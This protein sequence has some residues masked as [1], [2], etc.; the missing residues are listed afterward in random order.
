M[1]TSDITGYWC[2]WHP[3]PQ[4]TTTT[5]TPNHTPQ[6]PRA[7]LAWG[8]ERERLN[9]WMTFLDEDES[10]EDDDCEEY[11]DGEAMVCRH[12]ALLFA[13]HALKNTE[14]LPNK[15]DI[16]ALRR[17]APQELEKRLAH[18]QDSAAALHL[19]C[20]DD[21]GQFLDQ[22]FDA[23]KQ[24]KEPT[25]A[26]D[27]DPSRRLVYLIYTG[28]HLMAMQ[29]RLTATTGDLVEVVTVYDP[30]A[31]NQVVIDERPAPGRRAV[32]PMA[33]DLRQFIFGRDEEPTYWAKMLHEY[34][35]STQI[36]RLQML[37]YELS[38]EPAMACAD[39][40]KTA[41]VRS[42]RA[43][44]S[45]LSS[46]AARADHGRLLDE[47][48]AQAEQG[49]DLEL[50]RHQP[51]HLSA[52]L[53]DVFNCCSQERLTRWQRL[54]EKADEKRQVELL[55]AYSH[56]GSPLGAFGDWV[57]PEA[58]QWWTQR[59]LALAPRQ[60]L[61]VL[62]STSLGG[63]NLLGIGLANSA[64]AGLN[65]L[66]DAI[67]QL[68]KTHADEVRSLFNQR[69]DQN[70]TALSRATSDD[71]AEALAIWL[72]WL[73][74][75]VPLADHRALLEAKD[76][77]GDPALLNAMRNG[78]K[79]W[80]DTWAQG[81][82]KLP[83][84]EVRQLLRAEAGDGQPVL[85]RIIEEK[86]IATLPAWANAL[87]CL[88]FEQRLEILQE[89]CGRAQTHPLQ[90]LLGRLRLDDQMLSAWKTALD[91][92]RPEDRATWLKGWD[93]DGMVVLVRAILNGRPE[94]LQFWCRL[95]G[96]LPIE[97]RRAVLIGHSRQGETLLSQL[98][99]RLQAD[100][101]A[102][103]A[104]SPKLLEA[105]HDCLLSWGGQ[106]NVL[107]EEE[108]LQ[109]LVGLSPSGVP[110][111]LRLSQVK[112]LSWCMVLSDLYEEVWGTNSR[113][114]IKK[115]LTTAS[116]QAL[117]G[118]LSTQLAH[119]GFCQRVRDGLSILD[120]WLDIDAIWDLLKA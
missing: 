71:E 79:R 10:S 9:G 65:T 95:V 74:Q 41:W 19:I 49:S 120:S 4:G 100:A 37:L 16:S 54:W 87:Q 44:L 51:Q 36:E 103:L 62:A 20:A 42:P 56:S 92:L 43:A 67:D 11:K 118:E 116:H 64:E 111:W 97:H 12:F 109:A 13:E 50:L 30:N 22:A 45:L 31:T 93:A 88:P 21:F 24:T 76:E 59:L 110:A 33:R 75:W 32:D 108:R 86:L 25:D 104:V 81:L 78:A 18:L 40:L 66:S 34:F 2:E 1:E 58:R 39:T 27:S 14:S 69:D 17:Q 90:Q 35:G 7:V 8:K 107:T 5:A 53:H 99:W 112:D 28:A 63:R 72:K 101:D 60:V 47:V 91:V 52:L 84:E 98:C 82:Q 29:L 119:P 114:A 46:T 26:D 96:A 15:A 113:T 117:L 80:I 106:L 85:H 48:L 102:H 61:R 6:G 55:A 94:N 38:H 70:C 105:E 73:T 68:A 89:P 57:P 3:T 77:D 115:R 83:Q 23:L